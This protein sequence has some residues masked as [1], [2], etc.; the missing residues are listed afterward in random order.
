MYIHCP[1]VMKD[2]Q[3]KLSKRNGDAS[4][5]DLVAKGYLTE[6]IHNYIALC[7]WSP[8]GENEIFTLPEMIKAFSEEGISRSPAIFD[9]EKLRF[10]NGE[11]IRRL[12]PEAFYEKAL[13]WIDQAVR[14]ACDK[15]LLAHVLQQRCEVL[16]DIPAQLPFI[17]EVQPHGLELYTS[18]KMK[19]TPETAKAALEA[20][21]PA[22]EALGEEDWTVEKIHAACF[23]LI[24]KMEVKNGWMLWPMRIALSGM[25]FTPGGGIEIA[26]ILGREESLARLRAGLAELS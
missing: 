9:P 2:A 17:D 7:G 18:K 15:Q 13:P 24:A 20:L 11:Y 22:L 25:Q 3:N 4:Y 23:E 26:A 16:G 6:A 14:R 5:Q 19:T 1:P 21:I 12:S 8:K 10:M